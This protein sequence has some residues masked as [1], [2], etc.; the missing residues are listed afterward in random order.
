MINNI[1]AATSFKGYIPVKHFA[2]YPKDNK[3]YPVTKRKNLTKCQS[4]VVRN[5][6]GTAKNMKN[7]EFIDFYKAQ[8][9]DYRNCPVVHS[10]YDDNTPT[11]YMVTGKDTDNVR[12]EAKAVGIA[13]KDSIDRIGNT[14]SFEVRNISNDYFKKVK[15]FL[16]SACRQVK[17]QND[18]PL[19]LQV[20]FIPKYGKDGQ[21]KG[22]KYSEAKFVKTND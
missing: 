16:K 9:I 2:L 7:Q 8:D 4:F 5:L 11:I 14:K 10:V 3:F 17:S 20:Y 13:K 21:V 19:E 22:F 1:S 18:E 15:H 12:L 6:N